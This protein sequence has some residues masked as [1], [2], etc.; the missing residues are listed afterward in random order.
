MNAGRYFGSPSPIGHWGVGM[1][2]KVI[3][4]ACASVVVLL[5]GTEVMCQTILIDEL[6]LGPVQIAPLSTVPVEIFGQPNAPFAV[7]VG[8][9]PA[10][11]STPYGE[12]GVSFSQGGFLALDGFD[13]QHPC[14]SESF[15][16]DSGYQSFEMVLFTVNNTP[17][18]QLTFWTQCIAA[19][20]T[21]AA[22][23]ALGNTIEVQEHMP[24]PIVFMNTPNY[25]AEGGVLNIS[26][27]TSSPDAALN[28]VTIGTMPC[29]VIA[30]STNCIT[31]EIPVGTTSAPVS[32]STPWGVFSGNTNAINAWCAIINGVVGEHQAPVLTS[33]Y[34]TIQG[35]IPWAGSVDSYTV[36]A[37]AGQ[38]I[39]AECYSYDPNTGML[40]GGSNS[41]NL[42]FDPVLEIRHGSV[43]LF[44]DDDSGPLTSAAIGLPWGGNG[45][46]ADVEADYE[47]RVRSVFTSFVGHYILVVGVRTPVNMPMRVHSVYPNLAR[48]GD[49]VSVWCSNTVPGVLEGHFIH[50]F[51]QT[52]PA[53]GVVAGRMEFQ[54]P[55]GAMSGPISITTPFGTSAVD[56]DR[57]GAWITV[58]QPNL[59]WAVEGQISS[60]SASTTWFGTLELSSDYDVY[61][62]Q[63]RANR[64]Y[65][66]E[67]YAFDSVQ[68][69]VM[70]STFVM[71]H[72]A[73]PDLRIVPATFNTPILAMDSSSGPGLN[74]LIGSYLTPFYSNPQ[75]TYVDVVVLSWFMASSGDYLLNIVELPV[76]IP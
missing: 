11:L 46:V 20:V 48:P 38:E 49:F 24:P 5:L 31:V 9:A 43:D 35:C 7:A 62:V 27:A 28:V 65:R 41:A 67:V 50:A 2:S 53:S 66:V 74:A 61:R 18:Q 10:A 19:D 39:Y 26:G 54:I 76:P 57:M 73:D 69:R 51:G 15:L 6:Y 71:G 60:T 52:L 45:F 32:V 68:T 56:N 64:L 16:D 63:I 23:Y 34:M 58:I 1:V 47:V 3:R 12:L 59:A 17:G 70:T 75:D 33:G 4:A 25:A 8:F 30:A 42:Y 40:T 36:H 13:P 37:T 44:F 55:T 22:G 29:P 14:Y 72:P 21:A